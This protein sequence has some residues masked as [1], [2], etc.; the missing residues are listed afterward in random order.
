VFDLV[1]C[2]VT[3]LEQIRG[4]PEGAIAGNDSRVEPS[5]AFSGLEGPQNARPEKCQFYWEK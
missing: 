2:L 4:C 1:G 5:S 3:G